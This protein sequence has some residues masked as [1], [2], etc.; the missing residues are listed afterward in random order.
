M[1]PVTL[2]DGTLVSLGYGAYVPVVLAVVGLF[3][4]ISVAYPPTW[5]GA[6]TIRAL[7][8]ILGKAKQTIPAQEVK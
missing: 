3:S 1:D 7:A 2:L 4:A 5:K 8:L 6:A